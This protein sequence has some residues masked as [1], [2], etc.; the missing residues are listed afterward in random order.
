[1]AGLSV[2][3]FVVLGFLS[4][5]Y[6]RHSRGGWGPSLPF[7][8][9]W[10]VMEAPAPLGMLAW[11]LTSDRLTDPAA[12]AF[13]VLWEAHYLNRAFVYAWKR[14]G[15]KAK[16]IPVLVV[17]M[18][19][20]FNL[21][22]AALN[23]AWLFHLSDPYGAAWLTDPRFLVGA[24]LFVFGYG[25]NLWSDAALASL[26][27]PGESGYKIPRGGAYDWVS[28]PNYLGEIVEWCGWALATWSGAGLVFALWTLANLAPRAVTHHRWY[29]E[30]F[31]D[32]PKER[33]ALLPFV[34]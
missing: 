32:Y 4:A 23:G 21:I 20:V 22:N 8:V 6:G 9:G 3:I 17:G 34:V 1:M 18:A 25:L 30:T 19:V 16:P 33:R 24:A 10:A 15:G 28:C 14:R 12:V 29:Q 11:F 2:V 26:R 31:P 13:I 27:K 7:A 5:P